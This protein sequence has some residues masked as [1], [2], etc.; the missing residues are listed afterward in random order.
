MPALQPQPKPSGCWQSCLSCLFPPP[1]DRE[2][3]RQWRE[4]E[5]K[6]WKEKLEEERKENER[7]LV[8]GGVLGSTLGVV[9]V[10]LGGM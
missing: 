10:A 3:Q 2:L 4:K 7:R 1:P 6:E 5:N 8:A 9:V